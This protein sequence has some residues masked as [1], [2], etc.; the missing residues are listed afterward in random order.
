MTSVMIFS[1]FS[2]L[3][4]EWVDR[5]G[6]GLSW[7]RFVWLSWVGCSGVCVVVGFSVDIYF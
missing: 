4:L 3:D 1:S 2:V 5:F 6:W 7:V